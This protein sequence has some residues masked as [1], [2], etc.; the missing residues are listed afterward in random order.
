[1]LGSFGTVVF[2]VSRSLVRTFDGF[3]RKSSATFAEHAVAYGKAKLQST[4]EGLDEITFTM[5]LSVTHGLNPA[6]EIDALQEIKAAG[7]AQKLIIGG[8][9]VG[10]FVLTSLEESWTKIDRKGLLLKA[11]VVVSLKEYA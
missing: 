4:G 9:V 2:E 8:R 5:N 6:A 10:T 7:E 3:S 11:S 1:M